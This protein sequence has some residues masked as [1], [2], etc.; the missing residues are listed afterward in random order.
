MIIGDD[1]VVIGRRVLWDVVHLLETGVQ[2]LYRVHI[3]LLGWD[4]NVHSL[5]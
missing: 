5:R 2:E 1:T 4:G 3:P